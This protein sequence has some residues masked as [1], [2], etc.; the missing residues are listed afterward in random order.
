MRVPQDQIPRGDVLLIYTTSFDTTV[1]LL[2]HRMGTQQCFRY[3]FDLWRDYKLDLDG[4]GFRIEDPTG[5]RI[6]QDTVSKVYY[7]KPF[8]TRDIDA[9]IEIS[10]QD[11]YCEAELWY[12]LRDLTNLLWG[13]D[14]LVLV[15]PR[16]DMRI[17]K[18][19]QMRLARRYFQVPD[20]HFGYGR[21][22]P[23]LQREAV[24]KSLTLEPVAGKT[25]P[26]V[27]YT[28]RVA[29]TELSPAF[30]WFIQD[31]VAASKDVTVAF[32]RDR[33]FAFELDRDAFV[34]RTADWRE[35]PVEATAAQ[36]RPH[37]LDAAV[38]RAV[39]GFM[40]EL[41]LHYG[42]LDFLLEAGRYIFLEVNP[43]GQWGWLDANGD[44]GLLDKMLEE[45]SPQTP[46]HPL[47][48]LGRIGI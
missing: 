41:G 2:M 3:N 48:R 18:F 30:P 24:V 15:E 39:F 36:W 42:R 40:A 13:M 46:C 5:R 31:Y 26:R 19:V 28:T 8:T 38:E 35:L 10:D 33:V 44:Y 23:F 25:A 1:D 34:K 4:I 37:P 11:G 7:R 12:A 20:Y 6:D 32:V 22:G 27:I 21:P 9:R 43:N 16:A 17:G 29:E 47:P 45:L 14:K